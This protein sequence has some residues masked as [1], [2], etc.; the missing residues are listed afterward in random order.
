[1]DNN[2]DASDLNLYWR[3]DTPDGTVDGDYTI[4]ADLSSAGTCDGLVGDMPTIKNVMQYATDRGIV[5]PDA[6]E[7]MP[8]TAP[9][10]GGG[11]V[12]FPCACS[13]G[14]A[15]ATIELPAEDPDG[16]T[17]TVTIASVP[18]SGSLA[19]LDGTALSAGDTV[20]EGSVVYTQST[21]FS[22]SD[23]FTYTASDGTDSATATVT[24]VNDDIATADDLT[25]SVDE[26]ELKAIILGKSSNTNEYLEVVITSLP[27][28]GTLYQAA[29]ESDVTAAYDT[30]IE[31]SSDT[32]L[33]AI[34]ATGTTLTDA[35]G[36]VLY[37]PEANGFES[38][39]YSTFGYKYVDTTTTDESSEATVTL[40]VVSVNDGPAGVAVSAE[41]ADGDTSV[42]VTLTGSDVDNDASTPD[43]Y[44]PMFA[45]HFFA[46]IEGFP[47]LGTLYQVSADDEA[48]TEISSAGTPT[49]TSYVSKILRYSSQYS[50]CG[51]DCYSWASDQCSLTDE[52]SGAV[53]STQFPD[54]VDQSW[55]RGGLCIPRRARLLPWL[56]RRGARL[57]PGFRELRRRVRGSRSCSTRR[58]TSRTFWF[59]R[60]TNPVRST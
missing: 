41:V 21:T 33:V 12:V 3:F 54:I 48:D 30:M 16:D 26:D 51:A 11:E 14:S 13:S 40:N 50:V 18:S 24:I 43:A 59:T 55:G 6:P 23:T 17:V 39:G 2:P 1:M 28:K 56:W 57:G 38:S 4:E 5:V 15:S 47:A 29:F 35:R 22:T 19:T 8:S 49:V 7:Y 10:V 53:D 27:A 58:S 44:D 45:P 46:T 20:T 52:M 25:V 60:P 42:I 32:S 36:I 31:D 34:T 9:V 37:A